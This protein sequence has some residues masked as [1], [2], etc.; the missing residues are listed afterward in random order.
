[1]RGRLT[2]ATC[3][4]R[5]ARDPPV[6]R[7]TRPCPRPTR[8]FDEWCARGCVGG[9]REYSSPGRPFSTKMP[10]SHPLRDSCPAGVSVRRQPCQAKAFPVCI[11]FPDELHAA[12]DCCN[13]RRM[14][15]AVRCG[16][17]HGR[18]V[19]PSQHRL[20]S[21]YS[22]SKGG[23]IGLRLLQ[24][25]SNGT[26]RDSLVGGSP[27]LERPTLDWVNGGKKKTREVRDVDGK[28]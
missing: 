17:R 7:H 4:R 6:L 13:R 1:M 3:H 11:L 21:L 10:V 24:R 2:V 18:R 28:S 19:S 20:C 22:H 16:R 12:F 14:F 27:C 26:E 15:Q 8:G 5:P 9:R 25:Y 23:L